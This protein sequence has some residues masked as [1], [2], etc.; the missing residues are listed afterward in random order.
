MQLLKHD[1]ASWLHNLSSQHNDSL[2]KL[3]QDLLTTIQN[4]AARGSTPSR[5]SLHY[6]VAAASLLCLLNKEGFDEASTINQIIK[7][8][9]LLDSA[10][11]TVFRIFGASSPSGP[12][13]G[14]EHRDVG[15]VRCMELFIAIWSMCQDG[16]TRHFAIEG[17][18]RHWQPHIQHCWR[19]LLTEDYSHQVDVQRH[20]KHPKE[21]FSR[22]ILMYS[23]HRNP[24]R[25]AL[26]TMMTQLSN[27]DG[28]SS[29]L[30]HPCRT[31]LNNLHHLS[32]NVSLIFC[33]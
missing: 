20:L 2:Q 7:A 29:S 11:Q 33:C 13:W 14:F 8:T 25:A 9:M 26:L 21:L 24:L 23:I 32:F 30:V 6:S 28:L 1:K 18:E 12:R 16:Q 5:S 17:L 15:T 31:L 4:L 19:S 22:L 10:F 27:Q 3:C